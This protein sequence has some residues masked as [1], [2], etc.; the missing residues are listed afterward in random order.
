MKYD[1]IVQQFQHGVFGSLTTI[2]S[3]K[4]D[5]KI[6]FLGA[7]IKELLGFVN[8]TQVMKDARLK[9]EESFK[10]KKLSNP[11]F[12]TEVTTQ[13]VVGYGKYSSSITFI[14]ESGLYK[15]ILRS[16]KP[17]AQK[18]A[19]WV[20]SDV[21]PTLRKGVEDHLVMKQASVEISKHLDEQHQRE[22]S[23]SVNYRNMTEGGR[24]KTVK[25]NIKNCVDH[26]DLG[27]TPSQVKK[28]AE[29][30]GLPSSK[31]TSAKEV[32][33]NTNKPVACSMSFHDNLISKG[34]EYDKAL[35]VSNGVGKE[36]FKQ[37]LEIGFEPKELRQQ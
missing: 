36:L 12:F 3:L 20:T 13:S 15:L 18:F 32:F 33:R 14:S 10:F 35:S 34:I 1:E 9:P 27:R 25:Y 2:R 24:G 21:L 17:A 30:E 37:L 11:K 29:E 7:E 16:N 22:E 23:K 28:W 31:R 6:W 4:D 26:D 8:L 19:D 5:N